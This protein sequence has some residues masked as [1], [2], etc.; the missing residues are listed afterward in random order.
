[1][2]MKKVLSLILALTVA[3]TTIISSITPVFASAPHLRVEFVSPA[4]EEDPIIP[5]VLI[6]Q[7][8]RF[9]LHADDADL[10]VQEM[11]FKQIGTATSADIENISLLFGTG[12]FL[13]ESTSGN[14]TTISD[15]FII[16]EGTYKSFILMVSLKDTATPGNTVKISLEGEDITVVNEANGEAVG[17]SGNIP[18]TSDEYTII[19]EDDIEYNEEVEYLPQDEDDLVGLTRI[20]DVTWGSTTFP[21]SNVYLNNVIDDQYLWYEIRKGQGLSTTTSLEIPAS[22]SMTVNYGDIIDSKIGY[23]ER[24]PGDLYSLRFGVCNYTAEEGS[25]MGGP[26]C[27]DIQTKYFEYDPSAEHFEEPIVHIVSVDQ[28]SSTNPVATVHYNRIFDF[29]DLVYEINKNNARHVIYKDEIN[30]NPQT[31]NYSDIIEDNLALFDEVPGNT[32]TLKLASCHYR[33]NLEYISDSFCYDIQSFEFEY[34]PDDSDDNQT[35]NTNEAFDDVPET[36][37]NYTAIEYLRSAGI[38]HGYD[39]GMFRPDWTIS[40]IEILKI[41]MNAADIEVYYDP[42]YTFSDI[43]QSTWYAKYV[44]TAYK[45]GFVD[46]FDGKFWPLNRVS[47]VEALKILMNINSIVIPSSMSNNPYPDVLS[48]AWYAPFVEV[49]K[50]NDYI[51]TPSG[52]Y[53]HPANGINRADVA[54][55]MFRVLTY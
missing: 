26:N 13:N 29:F 39:D 43:D 45:L 3:T 35:T 55:V 4:I 31:I 6:T 53:F 8:L 28:G 12:H 50:N 9:K 16:P 46:G 37:Q 42:Y 23:F 40:R 44:S 30:S 49:A 24:A 25:G 36:H 54:E 1:M 2:I 19:D 10:E 18:L 41:A 52:E 5:G 21:K 17:L 14:E 20:V 15:N 48:G 33:V 34:S 47:K 11:I 7:A 32:Y 27:H 51:D 22:G 38:L